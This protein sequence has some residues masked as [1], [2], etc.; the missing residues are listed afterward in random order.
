MPI[1]SFCIPE[2][3]RNFH[4]RPPVKFHLTSRFIRRAQSEVS[5]EQCST[6]KGRL[7]IFVDQKVNPYLTKKPFPSRRWQ[8]PHHFSIFAMVL[9]AIDIPALS[10]SSTISLSLNGSRIFFTNNFLISSLT[11]LEAILSPWIC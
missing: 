7:Y 9:L 11:L 6:G 3:Y 10:S 8:N 2:C 4:I 5:V 1:F